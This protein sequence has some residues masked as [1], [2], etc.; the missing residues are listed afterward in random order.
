MGLS[1]T[2][3]GQ[4]TGYYPVGAALMQDVNSWILKDVN[5]STTY[6]GYALSLG[7]NQSAAVWKIRREVTTA[8]VTVATYADG[9][10]NYDN[11]WTNRAS[12][13]YM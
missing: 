5:G 10:G 12:L 8:T 9:D 11:V 4:P 7:A 13:T 3:V 2:T 1:G 6:Y